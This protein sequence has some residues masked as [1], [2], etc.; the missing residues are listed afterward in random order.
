MLDMLGPYF[1]L[2]KLLGADNVSDPDVLHVPKLE[3]Y[4]ATCSL[5][6]R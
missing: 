3:G 1:S 2:R 6:N 5:R 4:L